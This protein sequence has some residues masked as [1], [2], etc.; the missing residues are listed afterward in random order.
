LITCA[1]VRSDFGMAEGKGGGES[2]LCEV[3]G[4]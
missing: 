2:N 1:A 3:S 4:P